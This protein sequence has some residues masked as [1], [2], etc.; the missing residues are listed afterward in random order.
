MLKTASY[1]WGNRDS[2]TCHRSYWHSSTLPSLNP[3]SARQYLSSSAQQPNLTTEDYGGWS[4]LLS[5]SLVKP[6]PLS[7]NCTYPERAKGLETSLW[8]LT[9]STLP[10]WTVTVWSTLQSQN[11]QTQKQ[12][13][14][15]GNP[16]HE[17]LTLNVE[18]TTL[19]IHNLL[20][21]HTYLLISNLN[22]SDMYTYNCLYYIVFAFLY[23][24]YLYIIII[25]LSVSC[26][27]AVILLH[28]GASVTITNSSYEWTY[29][30]NKAH[31]LSYSA[32]QIKFKFN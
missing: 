31:C 26:P 25:L 30:A 15:S 21:T 5:E 11:D 3:S 2:S 18:H 1:F 19:L 8:T 13:L 28:S 17:H 22:M 7:K 12:F 24:A 27:V 20:T 4:G 9:S 29:L 6:S 32:I 23:F 10:L 14:P 16:S